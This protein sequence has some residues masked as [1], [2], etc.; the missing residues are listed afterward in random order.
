MAGDLYEYANGACLR[1]VEAYE[2][3]RCTRNGWVRGQGA[4]A[5]QCCCV[6][7]DARSGNKAPRRIDGSASQ[8]PSN[9]AADGYE[10]GTAFSAV[11]PV[12]SSSNYRGIRQCAYAQS[13]IKKV[14]QD[15]DVGPCYGAASQSVYRTALQVVREAT[16]SL[17]RLFCGV[18]LTCSHVDRW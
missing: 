2:L 4:T 7:R 14:D 11:K 15:R 10:D 8:M 6:D 3:K 9:V 17:V 5:R 1:P 16:P 13:S 12:K 18:R